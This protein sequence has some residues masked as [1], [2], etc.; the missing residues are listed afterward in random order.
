M[1]LYLDPI[2]FLAESLSY[3]SE[4]VPLSICGNDV[5]AAIEYLIVDHTTAIVV[6]QMN[7]VRIFISSVQRINDF[8]MD[9][10]LRLRLHVGRPR[11]PLS[12]EFFEF[13]NW[14]SEINK[15]EIEKVNAMG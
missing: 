8:F 9:L 5:V 2:I 7:N 6:I 13:V 11:L 4:L 3:S 15:T 1:Y 14:I 10:R 12:S